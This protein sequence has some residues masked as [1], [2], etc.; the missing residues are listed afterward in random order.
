M[1]R[2]F[3]LLMFMKASP[4]QENRLRKLVGEIRAQIRE[5]DGCEEV[6]AHESEDNP[7]EF[8]LY[9]RW[10]SSDVMLENQ[11]MPYIKRFILEADKI[12]E[13]PV[14]AIRWID[15]AEK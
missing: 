11:R 8:M 4:G 6:V 14:Q 7:N 2:S 15:I 3:A 13:S 10:A 12:S 5:Q 1:Q 9:Q